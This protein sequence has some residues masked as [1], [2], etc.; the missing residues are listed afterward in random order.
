MRRQATVTIKGTQW[1]AY[2]A[3]TYAELTTGLKGL[4]SIPAGSGMLFVLPYDHAVT[5]TTVGCYFP[6]DIVFISSQ[7]E[8]VSVARDVYPGLLVTESAA[9]EYILEV[10]AGEAEGI[11]AGDTVSIAIVN[12]AASEGTD[13]WIAPVVSFASVMMAG[14]MMVSMGKTMT[15]ALLK[16]PKK[17]PLIYGPREELLP[18]TGRK[19]YAIAA[20][21][22]VYDPKL[23]RRKT[24]YARKS[25]VYD[26]RFKAEVFLKDWQRKHPHEEF[27]IIEVPAGGGE[28]LPQNVRVLPRFKGYTVD[29]RLRE[30]RKAEYP[31]VLEFI[32][33]DSPKGRKLLREMKAAGIPMPEEIL[34]FLPDSLEFLAYTIDEIG[35][36]QRIDDAFLEAIARANRR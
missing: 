27:T 6:I 18:Q 10:N 33:F 19:G 1:Q 16:K 23:G 31:K 17:R 30:F 2:L 15:D 24:E 22:L 20:K 36:R 14:A 32:P 29:F 34:E 4:A 35:Y 9:V 28:L 26:D 5:V 25:K 3:T 7:C 13:G 8:V 21:R 12:E 11:E